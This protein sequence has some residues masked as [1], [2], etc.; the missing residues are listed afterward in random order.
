MGLKSGAKKFQSFIYTTN[1][2]YQSS[3][4]HT[5]V[6]RYNKE[7]QYLKKYSNFKTYH[8]QKNV[9]KT[10]LISHIFHSSTCKILLL[11]TQHKLLMKPIKPIYTSILS[12]TIALALPAYGQTS[13]ETIPLKERIDTAIIQFEKT[14]K[15]N[16]SFK[17]NRYENEEGTITQ[18]LEQ[19]DPKR[20]KHQRW[21]LIMLNDEAPS[22]K[23]QN[24]FAAKKLDE[25]DKH[26]SVIIKLAKL[27]KTKS[28]RIIEEDDVKITASFDVY[29]EQLGHK[30]SEQLKGTLHYSKLDKY[31]Q[32]FEITNTNTFSPVFTANISHFLMSVNFIK[33]NEAILTKE[34][35]LSMRGKMAWVVKINEVSKDTYY[36]YEYWGA[37]K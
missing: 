8:A 25:G 7:H 23:A 28:L 37:L 21:S 33:L 31:I 17:V 27:I 26:S 3:K 35:S 20:E 29:V 36:D 9:T 11:I 4:L 24:K 1:K 19:F 14:N 22:E 13:T 30:A 15:H 2:C 18:S 12:L 6:R 16:F 5:P 34:V 10:P 32:S